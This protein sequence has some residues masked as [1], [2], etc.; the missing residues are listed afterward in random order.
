MT[1]RFAFAA[2]LLLPASLF[3]L[4]WSTHGPTG[5]AV[6]QIAISPAAPLVVYAAS[7]AGVYR[8]DDAGDTWHAVGGSLNAVTQLAV[9]PTNADVVY[10]AT[11]QSV[12][13][14]TDGGAS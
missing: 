7:G 3:A 6:A 12:Y 10:A 4:D 8:S 9:D 11:A 1:P 13:K 5:G 14:S 2:L